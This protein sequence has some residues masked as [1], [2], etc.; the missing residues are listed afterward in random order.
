MRT[1]IRD[2][3]GC[4]AASRCGEYNSQQHVVE[5]QIAEK[6]P[7]GAKAHHFLSSIS[8]TTEVVPFQNRSTPTVEMAYYKQ[9]SRLR[10]TIGKRAVSGKR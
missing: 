7:S 6:H 1:D 5:A 10:E 4:D 9:G 3:A 8:G 2:G